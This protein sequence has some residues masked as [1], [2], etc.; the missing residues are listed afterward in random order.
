MQN[1][2]HNSMKRDRN[3]G[4]RF[5][6]NTANDSEQTEEWGGAHARRQSTSGNTWQPRPEVSRCGVRAGQKT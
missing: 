4:S 5:T 3:D 6:D 1:N 2:Q